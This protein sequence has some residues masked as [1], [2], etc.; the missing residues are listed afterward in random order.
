MGTGALLRGR[1]GDGRV[2]QIRDQIRPGMAWHG[3]QA[4]GSRGVARMAQSGM[5]RSRVAWSGVRQGGSKGRVG[6]GEE[7]R[8]AF[9][10]LLMVGF[11]GYGRGGKEWLKAATSCI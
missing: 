1:G 9:V 8:G 11:E 5:G 3:R 2:G 10:S 4:L 7:G 6:R